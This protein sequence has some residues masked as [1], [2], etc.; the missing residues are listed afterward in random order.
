MHIAIYTE[1]AV[2]TA[3]KR[4]RPSHV[5]VHSPAQHDAT[6]SFDMKRVVR[7]QLRLCD[8]QQ[9]SAV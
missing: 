3:A 5:T 6:D 8:H 9:E 1:S 4:L 7:S 2:L